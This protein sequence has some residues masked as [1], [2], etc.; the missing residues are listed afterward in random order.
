MCLL[1]FCKKDIDFCDKDVLHKV[2]GCPFLSK[3]KLDK[4][5][6]TTSKL[7]MLSN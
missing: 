2:T 7:Q 3:Q 1:S 6:K 5:K 4:K